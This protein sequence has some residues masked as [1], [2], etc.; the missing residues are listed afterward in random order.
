[1][2][3]KKRCSLTHCKQVTVLPSV[4]QYDH[5]TTL[6]LVQP[7]YVHQTFAFSLLLIDEQSAVTY[8]TEVDVQQTPIVTYKC[9][10]HALENVAS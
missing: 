1:M 5:I 4:V 3:K 8:F 9:A 2:R 6:R 10:F 7:A